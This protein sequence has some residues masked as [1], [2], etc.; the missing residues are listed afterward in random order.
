VSQTKLKQPLALNQ[1]PSGF[2][3]RTWHENA[4]EPHVMTPRA[5]SRG[6]TEMDLD[7]VRLPEL[8][9][10]DVTQVIL[11]FCRERGDGL[12]RV[13]VPHATAIYS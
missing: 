8:V 10:T 2:C 6:D 7:G 5:T 3:P 4:Y 13:F 11:E 12:C 9:F 1:A